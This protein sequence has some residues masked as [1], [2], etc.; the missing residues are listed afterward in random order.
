MN[1][2]VSISIQFETNIS[3]IPLLKKLDPS[4]EWLNMKI[5][6]TTDCKSAFLTLKMHK[7][8]MIIQPKNERLFLYF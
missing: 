6:S 8:L 4:Q 7:P 2:I 3:W 5:A 1:A